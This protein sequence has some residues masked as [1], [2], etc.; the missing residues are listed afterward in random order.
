MSLS[1]DDL[2]RIPA[3]RS[4]GR[5]QLARALMAFSACRIGGGEI[6]MREGES[7]RSMVLVLDGELAVCVGE[8]QI[9]VGRIGPGDTVGELSLFGHLERRAATVIT[10]SPCRLLILDREGLGV[11]KL[12]H[13]PL[14]GP[15]REH[16]AQTAMERLRDTYR[17]LSSA[18][19]GSQRPVT[20]KGLLGRW[21]SRSGPK[22]PPPPLSRV[23]ALDGI[24]GREYL[25]EL[26]SHLEDLG[27]VEGLDAGQLAVEHGQ[28]EAG[29]VLVL[30]GR[31]DLWH[32]AQSGGHL[33]LG[34]LRAGRLVCLAAGLLGGGSLVSAVAA[35]PA[36]ILRLPVRLQ[37]ALEER[38]GTLARIWRH[39]AFNAMSDNIRLANAAVEANRVSL[40]ALAL[41]F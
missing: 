41:R 31:L 39:A 24:F 25:P 14:L 21:L 9:E 15:L 30:D 13:S 27:E 5:M 8:D 19:P 20:R 28:P 40:G 29:P 10:A 35:E 1:V 33:R 18:V 34:R 38:N 3:L 37:G 7:D 16:A 26:A 2:A 11:L 6:L 4:V 12:D 32:P 23:L 22:T 36:W 17:L